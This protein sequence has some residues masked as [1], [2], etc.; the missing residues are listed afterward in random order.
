M[1]LG[2]SLVTLRPGQVGG[3]ESYLRDLLRELPSTN[4]LEAITVLAN[5]DVMA[6]YHGMSGGPISLCEVQSFKPGA[7][8]LSRGAALARA[9]ATPARANRRLARNL[10]VV[11][12]P[13]PV[14][15]PR[16][17]VPSVVTYHDVAHHDL[18]HLFS[19]ATRLWRR[20]AYDGA[21]RRA[22]IVVTVSEFSKRRLLEHVRLRADRV[23]AI[24]H[25]IDHSRFDAVE[26][27]TDESVVARLGLHGRFVVYPA[28]MWPHKN[29]DRLVRAFRLVQDEELEL[30]LTGQDY[31][32]MPRLRSL[33][34]SLGLRRRV[35]HL[36]YLPTETMPALYRRA[37]A[38]VFPS[39]YEGFG[40]PPME[41]MACGCPVATSNRGALA[42]ICGGAALSFEPDSE[43]SIAA[44][45]DRVLSDDPLR[46][47]LRRAGMERAARFTWREAADRH[48]DAYAEAAR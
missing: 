34:E 6:A 12:F 19:R 45:I 8:R 18:P 23:R 13:I 46:S 5:R 10:D 29:H 4:R 7:G 22:E 20:W 30:V 32:R 17:A 27:S 28:N 21:A 24:H 26:R 47:E 3:A 1:H 31:G 16:T 2:F 9:I 38:M 44:A 35:H 14:P 43:A 25:G 11:H 15:L 39:L 41:A 48:A 37:H 33:L 40:H 42:E 36:G